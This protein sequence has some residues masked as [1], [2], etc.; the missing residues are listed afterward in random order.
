MA[1]PEQNQG[2]SGRLLTGV[3]RSLYESV[4]EILANEGKLFED[5]RDVHG[6]HHR[7][8]VIHAAVFTEQY[9]S[10]GSVSISGG[11]F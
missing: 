1:K 2:N 8:Y 7:T 10:H 6:A 4:G 3:L 5:Y 11:L 9:A